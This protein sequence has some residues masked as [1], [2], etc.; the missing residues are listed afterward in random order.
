MNLIALSISYMADGVRTTMTVDAFPTIAPGLAVHI[1]QECGRWV[2][3]HTD[4]GLRMPWCWPT[5]AGADAFA[6][7]V[8][9]LADWTRSRADLTADVL[10]DPAQ[11]AL[12]VEAA[13]ATNAEFHNGAYVEAAK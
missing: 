12:L 1:G 4:S 13:D 11:R 8:A 5:Q 3:T 7:A 9:G 2:V 6:A 10:S